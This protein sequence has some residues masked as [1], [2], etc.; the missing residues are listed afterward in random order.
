MLTLNHWTA[1]E[2]LVP[3]MLSW[4]P[5]AHPS[6]ILPCFLQT[7]TLRFCGTTEFASGQWVGVELDEPEGKNDGSVGGVRYFICPPKQGQSHWG[8]L[9]S[10]AA[11]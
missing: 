3:V 1:R 4:P 6:H 5:K 2:F 7:G 8:P 10:D 9:S 11:D